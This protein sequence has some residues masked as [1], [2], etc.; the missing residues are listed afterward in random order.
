[1]SDENQKHCVKLEQREN[2]F[3]TGV[4]DVISFNEDMI[5][6]DTNMGVLVIG[7]QLIKIKLRFLAKYL[8]R[9]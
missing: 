7:G 6:I 3:V 8:N 1:M 9:I 2:I 5:V 4:N